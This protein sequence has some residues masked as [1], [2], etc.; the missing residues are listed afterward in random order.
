MHELGVIIEIVNTVQKICDEQEIEKVEAIVL[1]VGEIS[2]VVPRFLEECYPAAVDG[3]NM[4]ETELIIEI[5]P[6]NALCQSCRKVYHIPENPNAD[7][8][9][10]PNCSSDETVL[11]SG[12]ELNIKELRV[13][14]E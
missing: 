5:I 3:T 2:P 11:V 13:I 10:C 1:Q 6:A 7:K 4:Q 9:I 12:R 14:E 8:N